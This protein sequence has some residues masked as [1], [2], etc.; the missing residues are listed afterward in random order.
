M[1]VD[2]SRNH[3]M[4]C[5]AAPRIRHLRECVAHRLIAWLSLVRRFVAQKLSRLRRRGREGKGGREFC[6]IMSISA[7]GTRLVYRLQNSKAENDET[8]LPM[9]SQPNR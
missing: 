9:E 5:K 2:I 3:L 7:A 1:Q 8:C 4:L 6:R